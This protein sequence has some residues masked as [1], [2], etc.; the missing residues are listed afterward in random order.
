MLTETDDINFLVNHC[1][2]TFSLIIEKYAPLS[3]IRVSEKNCSWID[4]NLRDLM[5]IRD[6]LK[7][8]AVKDK[9]PIL[10]ESYRKIRNKVNALNV[11]LKKQ[12]Y[13]N[14]ISASK[15]NKKESWKAINELLN[16]RSK[17]SSI[18]C[19]KESGNRNSG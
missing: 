1:S 17:S 15:G 12:H 18:V 5:R 10:M 7:N 13:T 11:Q 9:S 4:E 2:E 3:E 16:K 8:S 19:L 14:R 6:K